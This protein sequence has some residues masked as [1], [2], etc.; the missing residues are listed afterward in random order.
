MGPP[1]GESLRR[2]TDV[3][4]EQIARVVSV[5]RAGYLTEGLRRTRVYPGVEA[6]LGRLAR[7]GV[8]QAV[9][10][11][12]PEAIAVQAVAQ[13]GLDGYFETVSG[14]ADDLARPGRGT[15]AL[16][17]KPA[18]I[19]E[20][21]HRLGIP[22]PDPQRTVMI[23]DRRYDAE[24]ARA[25]GL[26]CLGAGWGFGQPGELEA[27]CTAVAARPDE[28]TGLLGRYTA[29]GEGSTGGR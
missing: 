24:G 12:K 28:L 14:A 6:Q 27:A 21:L 17:D 25:H 20:A 3:P 7:A 8:R 10:T 16:H 4:E 19:A 5:Y 1:L 15:T 29:A 2:Y 22:T 9:A 23:G 13:R 11:Q 26:D 18:I